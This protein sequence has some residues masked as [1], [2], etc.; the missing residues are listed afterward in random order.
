[1]TNLAIAIDEARRHAF[2]GR[3]T[4]LA[5]FD[6]IIQGQGPARVLFVHGPGGIGKTALL[7]Q[8]RMRG[9]T[10]GRTPVSIDARDVDC[11]ADGLMAAFKRATGSAAP[12]ADLLLLDGY[13]RLVPIDSWVRSDFLPSLDAEMV[14]VL[15]GREPPS[16]PWRTDPGW[17]A[18][19][20]VHPLG[21]LS[22]AESVELLA[23]AGVG[24][25]VEDRFATLGRGHP[26]T[27]ALLADAAAAGRDVPEDIADAPDLVQT[28]V[29]QVIGEVP[30]EAH[31]TGLAVC[32]HAW[33][34]TEDLLRR[35][36]GDAAPDVWAWLDS[37]AFV[38]RGTEG[39]YPHDL[40]RDALDADL[41]RRS[42]DGYLR[43]HRIV[44]EHVISRLR[45]PDTVD[46]QLWAHHKLWLHR[47]SPLSAAYCMMRDHGPATVVGGE[48]A[49]HPAVLELIERF[50][51][52]ESAVIAERWLAA[53]PENLSVVR[54]PTG[55]ASFMIQVVYPTD[56][57]LC[58]AD[59]V[60][61]T[62]LDYAASTSPARPGEQVWIARYFGGSAGYQHDPYGVVIGAVAS[63]IEWVTRPLAWTFVP[64]VDPEFWGPGFTYIGFSEQLVT[65]LDGC[66]YTVYGVD[67]RRLSVDAWIDLLGERELTGAT[68]PPPPH[69]L[70]PQP[71]TRAEFDAAV[72]A[73]LRDIH[74]SERLQTNPLMG[75]TLAYGIGGADADLLGAALRAGIDQI[76]REPRSH[77]L[78]RV[79]DRTFVRAA[80]T[81]EAA[82]EVLDLPFST[83]RRHLAKAIEQLTDLLWAVEIG[84]VRLDSIAD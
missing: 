84:Q 48:L 81:Q 71:L 61:R 17:R 51:G 19:A 57:S 21:A 9:R 60:V 40:V 75:S 72:R 18:V 41:Q 63:T 3:S 31:A 76:G 7:D 32:A 53:Q 23:R 44:H 66:H 62:I 10:A 16:A 27:L 46:R 50:E 64:S 1:M 24:H 28:L 52:Q 14:V 26:L 5:R 78:H 80:P 12:G 59:P 55:L 20:T 56:P 38:T 37:Q 8:F 15:A 29:T 22:P 35:A 77:P 73:A 39:L 25:P 69:L 43:I 79:L 74:R 11:S 36:V 82:A 13:E 45:H 49:D 65:E 67:W 54:S 58:D 2:V 30:S 47:R 68:G 42:P 70:R 4:E 33:Q 83:Y 34:T 6:E